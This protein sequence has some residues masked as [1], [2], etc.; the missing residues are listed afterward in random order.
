MDALELLHNR[1]S[2][3]LLL[4]PA[5]TAEQMDNLFKAALRAPDHAALRPS[6]F[7]VVEGE[8]RDALGE[9]Y[10]KAGLEDDPELTEAKQTKLRNA[11]LRAPV[12]VVA[13]AHKTDHPKVPF[14]EQ[15]ITVGCATHAMLYAAHAQGVGAM[16]RTGP[17]A[18]HPTVMA[19]LGLA[20]NE[21]IVGFLYLGTPKVVRQAPEVDTAPYVTR[22][23]A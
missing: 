6:R 2:C 22:W 16:W 18:Y 12:V 11:P 7:L 19:G 17:M 20:E 10:L 8:Q 13:V 3:P 14:S 4:E 15:L 1:V 21:E 9:I 5:P 23:E